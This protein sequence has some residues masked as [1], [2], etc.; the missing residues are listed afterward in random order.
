[1]QRP[2]VSLI[3]P[4]AGSQDDLARFLSA[5]DRVALRAG[6]EVLVADNRRE[7]PIARC[8]PR[9]LEARGPASSYFA[10]QV[11]SARAG[12][13][14]LVFVDADTV[15]EPD[16]LDRYFD[17]AP[18]AGVGVLAG[19]IED[20]VDRDTLVARH[21]ARR[22]KL[23]QAT[24]LRRAR[25]YAQTANLAVRRAAFEA[26]GGFPDPV[27]SG[28]DAD[29]CWRL[30][31]AGWT[32]ESR[33]GARVRH[34][35]RA[36]LSALLAQLHRH[37][38]GMQWLDRR[39]PGAFPPPGPRELLARFALLARGDW[40][41]FLGRWAVDIGRLRANGDPTPAGAAVGQAP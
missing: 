13:E 29:L 37:G 15:P 22:R 7:P 11:A 12:G 31:A 38:S 27:R 2:T 33:P 21:I 40:I 4:F 34:R 20:W 25:P 35:N 24:T 28:A 6:D 1:V 10:R 3:A 16:L 8:D 18:A 14:W 17:P 30:A 32:L 9:V 41:D 26:V 39:Y 23:D 19:T 5:L 36:S